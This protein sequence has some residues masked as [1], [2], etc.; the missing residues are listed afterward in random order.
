MIISWFNN[1]S[2][3]GYTSDGTFSFIYARDFWGYNASISA[4]K[5]GSQWAL[6]LGLFEVMSEA[7]VTPD[8]VSPWPLDV[9]LVT[10]V[11]GNVVWVKIYAL[12]YHRLICRCLA[13]NFD[14]YPIQHSY[15]ICG[16]SPF[17]DYSA[18]IITT[19]LFSLTGIMLATG[20]YPNMVLFQVSELLYIYNLLR[21]LTKI[22]LVI[23]HSN[24][25]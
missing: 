1:A 19:S 2:I 24:D 9:F 16:K 18:P 10:L 22:L 4:C 11:S 14:P 3:H 12:R 20:N 8:V 7:E 21:L 6:A 23:F 13:A 5:K 25:D 15:G 17:C